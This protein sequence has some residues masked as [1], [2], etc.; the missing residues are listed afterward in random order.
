MQKKIISITNQKG[1]CGKTTI[2]INLAC[3]FHKKGIKTLLVD[4]DPQGSAGD[5][6]QMA[7]MNKHESPPVI[8]MPRDTIGDEISDHAENYEIII[9]DSPNMER[10]GNASKIASI[11][12]ASTHVIV[13]IQ[14]SALDVWGSEDIIEMIKT[15]Q[16]ITSG[17]PKTSIMLSRVSKATI[18]ETEVK[19][20]LKGYELPLMKNGTFER[21]DYKKVVG[22]GRSIFD[23]KKY[24]EESSALLREV[25]EFIK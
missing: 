23:I 2:A 14:P 25:M 1:G 19:S 4:A 20:L 24:N 7:A 16:A 11:I 6:R 22:Q 13:P 17:S 10:T 21:Q 15:R 12:K 9:I 8:G 18:L 5:W 3:G